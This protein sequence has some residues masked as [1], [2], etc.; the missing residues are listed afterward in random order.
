MLSAGG[1]ALSSAKVVADTDHE[2]RNVGTRGPSAEP[3]KIRID[4]TMHR[5]LDL[6]AHEPDVVQFMI[7]HL[8]KRFDA[9][10]A[11]EISGERVRPRCN[12][13]DKSAE[14]A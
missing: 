12:P 8:P 7:V 4:A 3:R 1:A 5:L 9:G 6:T 11:I 13:A 2:L 14:R 10:S